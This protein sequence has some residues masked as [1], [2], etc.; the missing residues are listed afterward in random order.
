M[1]TFNDPLYIFKYHQNISMKK[2]LKITMSEIKDIYNGESVT[3]WKDDENTF[4]S[5]WNVCINFPNEDWEDIK[6]E[7]NEI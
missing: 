7:L 3:V 4:L 1:N 6:K 5:I 2:E